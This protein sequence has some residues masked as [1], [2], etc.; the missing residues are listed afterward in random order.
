MSKRIAIPKKTRFEVFKRDSFT[1]QYCG[2]KAPDVILVIDHIEPVSK[3]GT[4]DILNLITSC[5]DCNAGK[6][7]RRLA[8][9]TVLDKRRQQLEEL[10]ERKDQIEMMFQWQKGLLDIDDQVV[11]KLSEYWSEQVPG[12]SL[13]ENGIK[14]LRRLKRKFGVDEIMTAMKIASEQYLEY[15]DRKPTKDSV[16]LAWKKVG[17]ICTIRRREKDNPSEQRL[18]YI[19]GIL[20]KRLS[21]LNEGMALQLL[22]AAVDANA[23]L[24]SLENH[25]KSVRNWTEWRAG[26]EGFVDRQNEGYD[27]GR[28]E[29]EDE[30]R[31]G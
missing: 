22:R 27:E 25:A 23:S 15:V 18:Y 29:V 1:C 26:I 31:P 7:D 24:E 2:R 13:N 14:M 30:N 19:R 20:R 28:S 4:N 10:Q 3:G 6:S 21:Y 9:T 12:F 11:S 8:D 17:G 16:E 5:R